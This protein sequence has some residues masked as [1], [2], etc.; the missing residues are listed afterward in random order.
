MKVVENVSSRER[1]NA[2]QRIELDSRGQ[3]DTSSIEDSIKMQHEVIER[4]RG[5]IQDRQK[6]LIR[7]RD[8]KKALEDYEKGI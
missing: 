4:L 5:A 1:S 8:E 3:G 6:K 2:P 7:L